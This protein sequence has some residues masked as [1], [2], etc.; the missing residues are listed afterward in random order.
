M[1]NTIIECIFY[2][3]LWTLILYWIHRASHQFRFL[4]ILH[5]QHHKFVREN[6]ITWH[7][8]NIFLFNDN[9]PSTFDLWLTEVIPTV[10]FVIITQQWWLGIGFYL[11]TALIQ[12]RIEHNKH[13]NFPV[14]TSGKWHL[15][16]HGH[17]AC[18]Y[19][20]VT[21]FWDCV[22]NTNKKILDSTGHSM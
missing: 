18:N 9:W 8:S 17:C 10:I 20:I 13:F 1:Y 6:T 4:S 5:R 2:F 16:H 21:P 3:F 15:L 22:F 11:W 14:L 12:E 7:W 19:G